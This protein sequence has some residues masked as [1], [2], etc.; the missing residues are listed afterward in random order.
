VV[1]KLPSKSE[2]FSSISN[3]KKKKKKAAERQASMSPLLNTTSPLLSLTTGPQARAC[4]LQDLR[5][6]LPGFSGLWPMTQP[7]YCIPGSPAYG[8]PEV[9]CLSPQN[10]VSQ[11]CQSVP[12]CTGV[13]A[14]GCASWRSLTDADSS[15]PGL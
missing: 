10:Q 13:D 1:Q 6:Q 4:G 9:G 14:I 8:Q 2:A 15:T 5:Q 11:F 3:T 7:H 12:S